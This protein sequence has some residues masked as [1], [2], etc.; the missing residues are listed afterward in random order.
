M[1][2]LVYFFQGVDLRQY[3]KQIEADLLE[4]EN[5][6]IQDCILW[7]KS[8]NDKVDYITVEWNVI[9]QSTVKCS[10]EDSAQIVWLQIFTMCI[11]S[12]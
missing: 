11:F 5:A 3:S 7:E 9:L 10:A 4:V 8:A 2:N 6:S 1:R 12:F